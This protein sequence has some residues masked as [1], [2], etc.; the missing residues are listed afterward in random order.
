LDGGI[1]SHIVRFSL[2]FK[3]I[4]I[5]LAAVFLGYSLYSLTNAKYD[6]FPEFAPP[7]VT[8]HAEAPGLSP[9]QVEVLVTRPVESAIKGV[10]GIVSMRSTSIQGFSA[11]TTTFKAGS[12]IYLARQMIA[13]RLSSAASELPRGIRTPEMTP[14]TSSTDV[15]LDIGLTS[16]APGSRRCS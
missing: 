6:V 14:L 12:D 10:Q 4:I 1:L 16:G 2:R 13:E 11:I 7:E 15:V 3:G 5:A 8:I 9:E